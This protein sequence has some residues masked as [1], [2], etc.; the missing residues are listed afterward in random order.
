MTFSARISVLVL[1]S[2]GLLGLTGCQ[3][4]SPST[5]APIEIA[6]LPGN[7]E[8]VA[9][10]PSPEVEVT[11]VSI[12]ARIIGN[13]VVI[14]TVG[15][16]DGPW[17]FLLDTGSSATLVSPEFAIRYRLDEQTPTGPK[18]WLR[19]AVGR[20]APADSILLRRIDFGPAHIANVRGLV[21]DC[22]EISNQLGIK[23]DGVLGFSLFRNARLT[24]DYPGERIV[25]TSHED[26]T[27]LRG[28]IVPVTK[29]NNVPLIRVRMGELDL[30]T[31]VDTGSDGAFNLDPAGM[32]LE[33]ITPPRRGAS[34][35]T[36]FG[37][38]QQQ[39]ARLDST[40]VIEDHQI[41]NPI[42]DLSGQLTSLGGAVLRN[43][44]ITFDQVREVAA[45]YRA[46]PG[47]LRLPAEISS[48]MSFSR[49]RAYWRVDGV[50]PGSPAAKVGVQVGDLIV[51]I[52]GEPVEQWELNRF[53]ELVNGLA[54]IEYTFIEGSAEVAKTAASFPLIP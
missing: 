32:E 7:V 28:C 29:H 4:P 3:L 22:G 11:S 33:F 43:F 20:A 48:G 45:F 5:T 30:M 13:L 2:A 31:L 44:E 1:S 9:P 18:V 25:L 42:V 17:R 12:P 6:P 8:I 36:L 37:S 40:L 46:E 47:P 39:I 54:D 34:V 21:H 38:H 14:E 19:D 50:V 10:D 26:R 41:E 15:R 35:K 16:P 52:E 27:P 53:T 23:I 49:N 24:I 51:R